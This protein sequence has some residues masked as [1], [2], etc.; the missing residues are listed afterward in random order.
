MEETVPVR[1][2]GERDAT[3]KW[4]SLAS[5]PAPRPTPAAGAT[6]SPHPYHLPPVNLAGVLLRAA[7]AAPDAPALLDEHGG[8]TTYRALADAA[9]RLATQ[10]GDDGVEPGDRVALVSPNSVAFVAAYLAALHAGA[11]C[12]PLHAT[13][14]PAELERQLA[15]VDARVTL[16]A[17]SSTPLARA[18]GRPVR[19]VDLD[20]LPD[21]AAPPV[22]RADD[23][24]AVLLFTSGTAGAPRAAML[25]H[26]NLAANIAQVQ[27]HPGLALQPDD[28]GLAVL[29]CSHIFGLNVVLG[30][31]LAAGG[32]TLLVERFQPGAS[33][34]LAHRHGVT[35]LAGV[36]TMFRDWLDCDAGA[37]PPDA[38][39][40]VRLA[41]SGAA[42]LPDA[43][44][45]GFRDR[46]GVVVHQGYGLTEASP[47]VSTTALGPTPPRPGS[48]GRPL[49]GV[50]VRLVDED[51]ADVLVGD[52]GEIWVQGPNVFAGYWGDATATARTLADGW[53][54]TGDVAVVDEHDDLRLVDRRTDLILVGGFNVYP[55]EV[56]E[57]LR[58]HPD[59]ADVAA[60]GEPSPR[61]GETVVAYVVAAPGHELDPAALVAHCGRALARY[62][63]PTRVEVVDALPR[64]AVGKVR[65]RDLG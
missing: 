16:A 14:P 9:A 65:R 26:A 57:A 40:S 33:A 6:F 12:V 7:A 54:H 15:A 46:Y 63:C 48:I 17:G 42:A 5:Q 28:V 29:P 38:F 59:V 4:R 58:S 18:A 51:G 32:A 31:G 62:K 19:A 37:A 44:A 53:L 24:L 64:T 49:P 27:G 35:V 11:V 3:T 21:A 45:T 34:R 41:V 39:A 13:S 55:A 25:T 56:E 50:T 60:V 23:D 47:I 43:V 20:T 8:R 1:G 22:D 52:P 10:L 30:C 36:P 2:R 61:T